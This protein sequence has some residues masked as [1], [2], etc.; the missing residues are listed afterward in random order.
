MNK[1]RVV[2]ADDEEAYREVLKRTMGL[3][4]DAEVIA[5]CKDGEEALAACL[6]DPPDVLLTDINMPKMNGI[7]LI[8]K[9]LTKEKGIVPV[10]L[11]V[12]E[13]DET[14]YEA[15]KAGAK[16]Y[17]LKT[18]SPKDVIEAVRLA[19]TG[20]AKVTPKIAAKM[21]EYFTQKPQREEEIDDTWL[22]VLSD[23]ELEVLKLVAQG[24]RNKEI[25]G[26]LGIAEKTVKNHVSNI[27][28]ALQ[29]N[30]RTELTIMA[31]KA[32]LVT[33]A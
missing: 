33:E 9:I 6:A 29:A 24:L 17:L 14:V 12:Q 28:K 1:I 19:E 2:I 7:E 20:E 27:L 10:I 4:P 11:T 25:A 18:S 32:K 23:R 3:A 30:S 15:F 31:L 16:G 13:D 8:Q 21:I 5:I 26:Q 22:Y